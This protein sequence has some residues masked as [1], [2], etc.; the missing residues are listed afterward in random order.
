MAI[1]RT[2]IIDDSGSGQDGTVIDN[3]WKQ[4]FYDQ[5]D[6]M[7]FATV[8]Q[9]GGAGLQH[10]FTIAAG[11]IQVIRAST[12]VQFTGFAQTGGNK[13]GTVLV[14]HQI[15]AG[16]CTFS[17]EHTGS[18][19]INRVALLANTILSTLV[20]VERG[21][22]TFYYDW[23]NRW[24]MVGFQQGDWIS[25]PFN[26]AN[27]TAGTATWTVDASDV[28]EHRYTLDPERRTLACSV[29][30]GQSTLSGTTTGLTIG[31]WPVTIPTTPNF[32]AICSHA[33]AAWGT[34]M[35]AGTGGPSLIF[36]RF[37][38]ANFP[39]STNALYLSFHA[40]LRI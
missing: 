28:T 19:D 7:S 13:Y 30:V 14:V 25:V 18:V 4:E 9:P 17:N 8:T 40:R 12:D 15:A 36:N 23:S 33:A 26:A 21:T 2:P 29:Y 20:M 24:M 27:Y 1:T 10:N 11:P 22:A 39:T 5:I 16:S 32:P 3:A 37:D 6:A 31:G 35:G 34:I 38:F